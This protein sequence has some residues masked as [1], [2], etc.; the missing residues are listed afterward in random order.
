MIYYGILEDD[1]LNV[2]GNAFKDMKGNIHIKKPQYITK[3][4]SFILKRLKKKYEF[5]EKFFL[6]ALFAHLVLLYYLGRWAYDKYLTNLTMREDLEEENEE[7]HPNHE[8]IICYSRVKS[9]IFKPCRHYVLCY[10]C[11]YQLG[12]ESCPIC[13]ESIDGII[14]VVKRINE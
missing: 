12:S 9:V 4:I 5:I 2:V 8:C 11:Y 7:I 13:K 6:F 14:R 3:Q 1:Y 10:Q